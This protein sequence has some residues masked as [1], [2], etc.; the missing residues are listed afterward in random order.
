MNI[1]NPIYTSVSDSC[2]YCHLTDTGVWLCEDINVW[3]A[4]I[5][6]LGFGIAIGALIMLILVLLIERM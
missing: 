3:G 5:E 2:Y 4:I 6:A 1:T